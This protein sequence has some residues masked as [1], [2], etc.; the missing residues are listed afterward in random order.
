M[1][2]RPS[3]PIYELTIP[4]TGKTVKYR[5]FIMSDVKSLMLAQM[6]SDP[7]NMVNTL[8]EIISSCVLQKN[9]D[10]D[11]LAIFDIEKIFCM[12]RAK[13]VEENVELQMPCEK[14]EKPT[15]IT[16]DITKIDVV[17]DEKHQKSFNLFDNVGI[18]MKYPNY[19]TML[20]MKDVPSDALDAT[21]E[22][23]IDCVDYI[24]DDK[25]MYP[26]KDSTKEELLEFFYGLTQPQMEKIEQFFDTLPVFK[27]TV[28][29][30][31]PHCEHDNEFTLEGIQ[32]FF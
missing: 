26:A 30:K 2:P 13:S 23:I 6:S 22:I 4:S 32:N 9:F 7:K 15:K 1:L 16:L 19:D 10:V 14:C 12:L 25:Q 8:K 18:C 28:K 29:Y 17:F 21:F 20:K 5:P 11:S 31:C 3:T 27:E 24:Y